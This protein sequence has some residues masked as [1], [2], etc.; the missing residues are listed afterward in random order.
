ML[1]FFAIFSRGG[2][3]LWTLN[4]TALRH[5]P[6]DALNALVRSCLMEERSGVNTFTY[7]PKTGSHQALKWTFHNVGVF[8]CI[9]PM[10]PSRNADK[11]FR[12]GPC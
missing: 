3:L 9:G 7:M 11:A 2:A 1:D 12:R 4:F 5:D 6:V 10:K 8:A